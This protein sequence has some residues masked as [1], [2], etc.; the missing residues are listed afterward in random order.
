MT[1]CTRQSRTT[2]QAPGSIHVDGNCVDLP[3]DR[4][5]RGSHRRLPRFRQ[6]A[7]QRTANWRCWRTL[8]A[9]QATG[10][11]A[12]TCVNSRDRSDRVRDWRRTR[13][14][15]WRIAEAGTAWLSSVVAALAG[16][17]VCACPHVAGCHP[18]HDPGR[19]LP[20]PRRLPCRAPSPPRP[21]NEVG[22]LPARSTP[23][24]SVIGALIAVVG[25]GA[26]APAWCSESG[27]TKFSLAGR[28]WRSFALLV[29]SA[30]LPG[31]LARSAQFSPGHPVRYGPR[32]HDA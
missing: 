1:A 31:H 10:P 23:S 28:S 5:A 13:L 2:I 16:A 4:G 12:Q 21:V 27:G 11:P 20:S 29:A 24:A 8:G 14:A 19:R 7:H 3:S 15:D 17:S 26:V 22:P 9:D 30:P 32:E 6:C 25:C 18:V